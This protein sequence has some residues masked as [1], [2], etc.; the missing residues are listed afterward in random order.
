MSTRV[1]AAGWTMSRSWRIFAPSLEMVAC[2][3]VGDVVEK[4]GD[5]RR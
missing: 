5:A 4:K 1:L 2:G 3:W